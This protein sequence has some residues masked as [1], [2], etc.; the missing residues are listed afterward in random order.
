MMR[1]TFLAIIC[2][3]V[4]LIST[5]AFAPSKNLAIAPRVS[6]NTPVTSLNVFGNK[7]SAAA[8]AAEEEKE[9]KFWQG[10]WVCKDCGYIYN[11]V[12]RRR[13]PKNQPISLATHMIL[14]LLYDSGWMR[15]HVLWRA[16]SWIPLSSVLWSSSSLCQ[17]GRRPGGNNA[18]RW[19]CSNSD[20]FL[21]R[22]HCYNHFWFLGS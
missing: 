3:F 15:R 1:S 7:K 14:S 4:A 2:T 19:R 12:G 9:A 22:C 21:W 6:S 13:W 10:E 17:E 5:D 11:R 16:G 20:L 8:R 18:R